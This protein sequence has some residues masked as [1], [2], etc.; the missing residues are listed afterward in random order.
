MPILY[1][2]E[3]VGQVE[4]KKDKKKNLTIKNLESKTNTQN[5]KDAL[6]VQISK[7][8]MLIKE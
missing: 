3:F 7:L 2:G 8:E 4:L 6:E 5:F 1:N